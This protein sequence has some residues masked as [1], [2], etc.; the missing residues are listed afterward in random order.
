MVGLRH[1]LSVGQAISLPTDAAKEY[2][3]GKIR[4]KVAIGDIASG[5]GAN[6]PKSL[7]G[8]I[9]GFEVEHHQIGVMPPDD[10]GSFCRPIG[11]L[12]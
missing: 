5:I 6:C 2:K 4:I 8:R 7:V 11:C 1:K 12:L 10:F 3:A 9:V